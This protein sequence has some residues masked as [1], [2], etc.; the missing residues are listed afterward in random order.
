LIKKFY[1]LSGLLSFC[2]GSILLFKQKE[3]SQIILL[4]IF[5]PIFMSFININI[6]DF[7]S[8]KFGH[9]ITAGFNAVQF[10]IKSI[11]MIGMMYVGIK[12]MN[13]NI[14]IYIGILC[15]T[16][17]IFHIIEGF[18]TNSLID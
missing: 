7:I 4:G 13:L 10:I 17:L 14:P 15:L 1:Y 9:Q 11:F 12:I 2:I 3:A 8:T 18:Y 6:I 5:T 16:W